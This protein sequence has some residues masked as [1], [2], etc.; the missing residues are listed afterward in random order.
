MIDFQ[1]YFKKDSSYKE[2]TY[3]D[4]VD[5][6]S[7]LILANYKTND[8]EFIAQVKSDKV[9]TS[10]FNEII[11]V[12]INILNNAKDAFTSKD[13]DSKAVFFITNIKN[14]KMEITIKDNAG[15]VPCDIIDRIFEPYFT[16]KHQ[17]LGTGIGLYMTKDIIENHLGG[18]IEVYNEEVVHNNI[19]RMGAVFKITIPNLK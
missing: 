6:I 15:G 18:K 11:Q 13:L 9:I 7:S 8:I 12:I 4:L 16:T 3:N 10:M 17:F 2:F 14:K 1:N 19:H 5:N